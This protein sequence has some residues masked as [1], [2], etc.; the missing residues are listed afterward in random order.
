MPPELPPL[1]AELNV[2]A[3]SHGMRRTARVVRESATVQL[4]V[5]RI[6]KQSGGG[7]GASVAKT[8]D[9]AWST[10]LAAK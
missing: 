2:W 9:E 5:K 4:Q 3:K 1:I 10:L 6:F 7:P 8:R